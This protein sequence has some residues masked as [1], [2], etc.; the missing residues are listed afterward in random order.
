VTV[1]AALIVKN[2]E[3]VL[4]RCLESIKGAVDEI[5]IVDTGSEDRTRKIARRYTDR[6]FDFTWRQDFAA[7]RQYAFDQATSD[8][9]IWL[10]ADDV[11]RHAGAIR[12]LLQDIPASVGLVYW[13][14]EY[15][16]DGQGNVTC[17]FWRER[18]ARRGQGRWTGRIHETLSAPGETQYRTEVVVEHHP[19]PGVDK[20]ERNIAILQAAIAEEGEIPRLL[21][22]LGRDLAS[23]GQTDRALE[24]LQRYV[25]IADWD[26][27]K[28]QAQTRIAELL[29]W[30]K[31]YP[32]ALDADLAALKIHPTWPDAYFGLART[33]YFLQDWSKVVH[34]SEF[35]EMLATP[36][37]IAILDPMDYSFN[38]IIYYTVALYHVG[39]IEDALTWTRRA[40]A[41]RPDD[42]WH[43]QNEAL[44]QQ[45]LH[46][47]SQR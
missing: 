23:A 31:R 16:F 45:E 18:C 15:A 29:R 47:V 12:P 13:R 24:A 27:E 32:E 37:T 4:A 1:S 38:W 44:F 6:V 8:W 25:Q 33:Y 7:A 9:V 10:D 11:V 19:E 36:E 17:E 35:G 22:Y 28:Y 2:E 43:R 41:L 5:V 39:R 42:P 34:W 26:D 30:Q 20:L 21:F 14:Y 46:P 3:R 40:L